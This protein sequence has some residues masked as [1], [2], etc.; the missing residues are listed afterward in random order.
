MTFYIKRGNTY[1]VTANEQLDIKETLPVGTYTVKLSLEGFYLEM[2][3]DFEAPSKIYGD[4]TKV[5]HKILD[6]FA[7]RTNATGVLLSG[8]QGSG[9]T[10]QGEVISIEARDRGIPTFVINSAFYG[11]AFN[12]FMQSIEQPIIVLFDEFEK[13]YDDG[14]Q[15]A[16]LTLLDGVYPTKKLFVL[17]CNDKYRVNKHMKN[18]PGRIFYH[19][20]YKGLGIDFITEYSQDNLKNKD[21]VDSVA[22]V[23]M[24]FAEF[25]FDILKALIEEMNRYNETAAEAMKMLNARPENSDFQYFDFD[26]EVD[27]KVLPDDKLFDKTWRGNPL[28]AN[29]A[30]NHQTDEV[31]E[32]GDP[33]YDTVLFTSSNIT[34]VDAQSGTFLYVNADGAKLSL[35]KRVPVVT[36]YGD[37]PFF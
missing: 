15:Q 28:Q 5:A 26:L 3:D 31:D 35:K 2:V 37:S 7:S 32:D 23:S 20:E 33:D 19:L 11:E 8:E 30:I 25:N 21:H 17:T 6:T 16:L 34:K 29:I 24:L 18:R 14:E 10:L 12:T 9:K 13:V 36:S 1:N 4:T 27:G 22:R